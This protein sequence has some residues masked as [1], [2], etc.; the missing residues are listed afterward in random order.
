MK[1]MTLKPELCVDVDAWDAMN[2]MADKYFDLVW[3]VR[4]KNRLNNKE[5]WRSSETWH[6]A[7]VAAERIEKEYP[8]EIEALSDETTTDW[9]HGFNSGVLATLRFAMICISRVKV[10]NEDG[11]KDDEE[12]VFGGIEDAWSE[13]PDI[14]T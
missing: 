9:M 3:Y 2:E 7:S 11:E 10:P 4:Y 12:Y 8:K 14:D 1:T 13:F 6:K 5:T